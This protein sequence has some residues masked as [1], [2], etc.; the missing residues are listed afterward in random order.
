[1]LRSPFAITASGCSGGGEEDALAI[2]KGVSTRPNERM[3]FPIWNRIQLGLSRLPNWCCSK[4]QTLLFGRS[5][6][7]WPILHQVFRRISI[8]T[9][10]DR[11]FGKFAHDEQQKDFGCRKST[12]GHGGSAHEQSTLVATEEPAVNR[13][14]DRDGFTKL[15]FDYLDTDSSVITASFLL[16]STATARITILHRH[17]G[18]RGEGAVTRHRN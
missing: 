5:S 14:S 18:F 11:D 15:A 10:S 8:T 13:F 6:G 17:Q 3:A 16:E 12:L 9:S 1:M 4:R 2:S 7:N